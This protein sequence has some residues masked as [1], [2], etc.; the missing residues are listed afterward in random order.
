MSRKPIRNGA[1]SAIERLRVQ[2]IPVID[3]T[4]VDLSR[5]GEI[6]DIVSQIILLS[7]RRGQAEKRAKE[8]QNAA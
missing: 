5:L 8:K 1:A 7:H 4:V 3:P 6:T 2:L